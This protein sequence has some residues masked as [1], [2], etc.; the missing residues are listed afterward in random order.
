MSATLTSQQRRVVAVVWGTY[1]FYYL[2]RLNLSSALPALVK[3]LGISRAEAGLLGTVFFW[4]Y[5]LG[6]LLNG[7]LGNYLKPRYIV[8]LGL[9]TIAV[10][11]ILFSLQSTLVVMVALWGVNGLAQASG[12]GPMMRLLSQRL[13]PQQRRRISSFF[14]MSFQVGTAISWALAGLLVAWGGWPLAF[15]LPGVILLGVVVWWWRADNDAATERSPQPTF[16]WNNLR[17]E[18]RA[19]RWVLPPAAFIGF[20]NVGMVIWLPSYVVDVGRFPDALAGLVAGLMSLSGVLGMLLGGALL[21]RFDDVYRVLAVALTGL[22]ACLALGAVSVFPLQFVAI[23]LSVLASSGVAG[24]LLSSLPL[25]LAQRGQVSSMAGS[26]T[27]VF[28]LGGSV[29]GV[30]VGM[31]LGR[32]GSWTVVFWAW[33]LCAL[34]ALVLVWTASRRPPRVFKEVL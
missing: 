26:I 23:S 31:L 3:D 24:L 18:W 34:L 7:Q 10:S 8:A 27:A 20:V 28:N 25:A 15:W 9:V 29:A 11:N 6:Q 2:G 14:P 1:A 33:S 16:S 12:W 30:L 4:T 17:E 21:Q 19:L 5:T 32:E 22:L 13:D